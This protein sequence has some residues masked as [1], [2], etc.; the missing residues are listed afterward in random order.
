MIRYRA[1]T[2]T[3]GLLALGC[4]DT[5]QQPSDTRRGSAA[6]AEAPAV[7]VGA[8]DIAGCPSSYKDEATAKLL[9]GIAGT[10]FTLG[11]N[12]YRD[13]TAAEFANCYGPSWG[14]HR[15][16]THPAIGNHDY[17]S[18]GGGYYNYFGSRARP[19]GRTYY[20]YNLGSWHIVVLDSERDLTQQATWLKADLATNPRRC[21]MAY[22]HKPY[23]TTGDLPP[24][25]NL[26]TLFTILYN[27]GA[28]VV[29]AGHN[30]LYERFYPQDPAGRADWARGIR[31]FVVGTGGAPLLPMKART[32]NLQVRQNT[33]HG[34]LKFSLYS[35]RYKWDFIPVPGKTFR[36][37]ATNWCH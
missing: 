3:A 13:G 24:A 23:F 4:T 37:S 30:H 12:V 14:R 21:T 8:G 20:S 9:D 11:D 26:R 36:D 32:P 15:T 17:N 28:D 22:W 1:A 16:R 29:L 18:G 2:L 5:P 6:L 7:L 34:V 35:N 19:S 33:A 31:T 10:V 25:I 27:A